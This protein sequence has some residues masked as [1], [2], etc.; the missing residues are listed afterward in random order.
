MPTAE[1][2]TTARTAPKPLTEK[3]RKRIVQLY[4]RRREP[5]SVRAISEEVGRSF[6]AVHRVLASAEGVEMRGQGGTRKAA[7]KS[8]A[9]SK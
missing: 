4:T 8:T 3:E 2:T 6:G 1:K 5:L 9:K 7:K